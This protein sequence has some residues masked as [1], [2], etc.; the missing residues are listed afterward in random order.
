[1]SSEKGPKHIYAQEHKLYYLYYHFGGH[2]EIKTEKM[3]T[4]QSINNHASVYKLNGFYFPSI[5]IHHRAKLARNYKILPFEFSKI[6][7][8]MKGKS[9]LI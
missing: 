3:T 4:K 7:K 9:E 5:K 1:M 6:V 8:D 2:C